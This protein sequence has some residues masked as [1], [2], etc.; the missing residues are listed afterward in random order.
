MYGLTSEVA[1]LAN[2]DH[3]LVRLVHEAEALQQCAQNSALIQ[4]RSVSFWPSD[5][6]SICKHADM[7]SVSGA[8]AAG[9][10]TSARGK[11]ELQKSC[12]C[13]LSSVAGSKV[14]MLRSRLRSYMCRCGR[15]SGSI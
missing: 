12:C 10:A 14:C 11:S 7:A 3:N 2:L 4:W 6:A 1:V 5:Y 13:T 9:F 8:V 15:T